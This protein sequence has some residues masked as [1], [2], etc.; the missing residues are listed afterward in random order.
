MAASSKAAWKWNADDNTEVYYKDL[1]KIAL[2]NQPQLATNFDVEK[3]Q[4]LMGRGVHV[5]DELWKMV[6]GYYKHFNR[7]V[8]IENPTNRVWNNR[9]KSAFECI[10]ERVKEPTFHKFT[11]DG[12]RCQRSLKCVSPLIQRYGHLYTCTDGFMFT[13]IQG[14]NII[15]AWREFVPEDGKCFLSIFYALSFY[16]LPNQEKLYITRIKA[17]ISKLTGDVSLYRF[18]KEFVSATYD[19]PY[20]WL[21]PIPP[22]WINHREDI[23]HVADQRGAP[24]DCH[25]LEVDCLKDLFYGVVL[26]QHTEINHW[27]LGSFMESEGTSELLTD[28]PTSHD[29]IDKITENI[30]SKISYLLEQK[31]SSAFEVQVMMHKRVSLMDMYEIKGEQVRICDELRESVSHWIR[32]VY[33]KQEELEKEGFG[34][35]RN[36]LSRGNQITW[37]S[38]PHYL[39]RSEE[40]LMMSSD[41][42][43]LPYTSYANQ[44]A[45]KLATSV[46][47]ATQ[48]LK[49]VNN[50]Y[51]PGGSSGQTSI[52]MI[53]DHV[54]KEGFCYMSIFVALGQQV[55]KNDCKAYTSLVDQIRSHLGAW[56]TFERI[57]K[58][59]Y[60]ILVKFP[61]LDTATI[62]TMV[63]NK[64]HQV[65]H[66]CDQRGQPNHTT[67]ILVDSLGD[68]ID[69]LAY[70]HQSWFQFRVG[71][72]LSDEI[73]HIGMRDEIEEIQRAI[74]GESSQE[75]PWAKIFKEEIERDDKVKKAQMWRLLKSHYEQDLM[76]SFPVRKT[77]VD[78]DPQIGPFDMMKF[79]QDNINKIRKNWKKWFRDGTM[80]HDIA[81]DPELSTFI[82]LSPATMTK[83]VRAIQGSQ[84]KFDS[85]AAIFE[86]DAN[87]IHISHLLKCMINGFGNTLSEKV[88]S[89]LHLKARELI[90]NSTLETR[91]MDLMKKIAKEHASFCSSNF[92]IVSS[93]ERS[94][95]EKNIKQFLDI[96][97][98]SEWCSFVC[99]LAWPDITGG[100]G[101][102]KWNGSQGEVG[103]NLKKLADNIFNRRVFMD[104]PYR[105]LHNFM[106]IFSIILNVASYIWGCCS[107]LQ[108]TLFF[109]RIAL[110]RFARMP[111]QTTTLL[112]FMTVLGAILY[113]NRNLFANFRKNKEFQS[114]KDEPPKMLMSFMAFAI[115]I[116]YIFS[117]DTA[118]MLSAAFNHF[119]RLASALI[120]TNLITGGKEFQADFLDVELEIT[121][122]EEEEGIVKRIKDTYGTWRL[123]KHMEGIDN[124]RPLEYGAEYG[125]QYVI[126]GG[127]AADVAIQ[128]MNTTKDWNFVLGATGSGKSTI[129]PVA[130][131]NLLRQQTKRK[132]R[133]L[134]LQPTR[135]ATRNVAGGIEAHFGQAIYVKHQDFLQQGHMG[136]Q[137]M[138][139]G[140]ALYTHM[141]NE[142]FLDQFDTIFLD[143]SHLISEHSLVF[144]SVVNLKTNI[145]KFYVTATPRVAKV[146][147]EPARRFTINKLQFDGKDPQAWL[148]NVMTGCMEDPFNYGK[149][150]LTF[151]TGKKEA[152][153]LASS[154]SSKIPEIK[155]HAVHSDNFKDVIGAVEADLSARE[156]K[157]MVFSTN[158]FETGVT[159]DVDVVVDFGF[160]MRPVLDLSEKTLLLEKKRVTANQREQRVG[161]CG[162]IKN[163]TALCF[164]KVMNNEQAVDACTVY[165]AAILSYVLDVD[166]YINSHL[167]TYWLENITR[168]QAT[169][170]AALQLPLFLTRD[171]IDSEGRV[172]KQIAKFLS[173]FANESLSM[174]THENCVMSEKYSSWPRLEEILIRAFRGE[175]PEEMQTISKER[176]PFACQNLEMG[177]YV[178]LVKALRDVKP[179]AQRLLRSKG[180]ITRKITLDLREPALQQTLSYIQELV[181]T[182]TKALCGYSELERKLNYGLFAN[183][184]NCLQAKKNVKN[185][186]SKIQRN[187]DKVTRLRSRVEE[188]INMQEGEHECDYY[189][190]FEIKKCLEFQ[191]NQTLTKEKVI[192]FCELETVETASITKAIV[193][194]DLKT[195]LWGLFCLIFALTAYLIYQCVQHIPTISTLFKSGVT[196]ES[197][198][199]IAKEYEVAKKKRQSARDK[200]NPAMMYS[201]NCDDVLNTYFGDD[202]EEKLKVRGKKKYDNAYITHLTREKLPWYVFYDISN[203]D[204]VEYAI[205][206]N[207]V[208]KEL[209]RTTKPIADIEKATEATEEDITTPLAH[210]LWADD[211]HDYY[212]EVHMKNGRTYKVHMTPHNPSKFVG[213]G[214][215]AGFPERNNVLRQT[216]PTKVLE[217]MSEVPHSK[218]NP[219]TPNMIGLLYEE[220]AINHCLH[221]IIYNHWL[222]IPGH[223]MTTPQNSYKLKYQGNSFDVD[224]QRVVHISGMDMVLVPKPT[225]LKLVKLVARA[226]EMI[227]PEEITFFYFSKQMKKFVQSGSRRALKDNKPGKWS[228]T[229]S[230]AKGMCGA[231]VISMNTGH[232]VGIHVVGDN[233]AKLNT[234]QTFNDAILN[235]L[236]TADK[237]FL[238]PRILAKP[239][240]LGFDNADFA[241]FQMR[242]VAF[243]Q[244]PTE[245]IDEK[246][247]E[248]NLESGE[249]DEIISVRV[250]SKNG[251]SFEMWNIKN[252]LVIRKELQRIERI[253]EGFSRDTTMY[254]MAN[255]NRWA[256]SCMHIQHRRVREGEGTSK[257]MQVK[258]VGNMEPKSLEKHR[259]LCES[260]HWLEFKELH[261]ELVANM[262]ELEWQYLPSKLN[263]AAYWKDLSKY[264]HPEIA[265]PDHK[266]LK[267]AAQWVVDHLKKNGM[268][269]TRVMKTEQV[270]EDLQWQ[271]AAGAVYMGAKGLVLEGYTQDQIHQI[272]NWSREG[273]LEGI[274]AGI[275]NASLKAELRP[276][277]KI[278]A[279]KTRVFTAAPLTTLLAS[280]FYVDSFNKQFYES[281]LKANHTVGINK[282]RRGWEKL[283]NKLNKPNSYWGGGDG[284][285]YDSSIEPF[286]FDLMVW[287]RMQFVAQEDKEEFKT[288]FWNMYREFVYTPIYC[289]DGTIVVKNLGQPS[290]QPSTVVDNTIILMISFTYA[291]IRK[292]GYNKA[293]DVLD[294]EQFNFV[295]NGDD[296]K[297]T[298]HESLVEENKFD[299]S[300]QFKELGLDYKF[301]ELTR[302]PFEHFYMSLQFYNTTEGIG[303]ALEAERLVAILQWKRGKRYMDVLQSIQAACVESYNR[304]EIFEIAS[305]YLRWFLLQYQRELA[306]EEMEEG[307]KLRILTEIETHNLHYQPESEQDTLKDKDFANKEFQMDV[308]EER[309]LMQSGDDTAIAEPAMGPVSRTPPG[310]NTIGPAAT[311]EAASWNL[312]TLS[313]EQIELAM[314][315]SLSGTPV[316]DESTLKA[317][318]YH[319]MHFDNTTATEDQVKDW[320]TYCKQ[321]Y[322]GS[323]QALSDSHFNKLKVAFIYWCADNGTSENHDFDA[324]TK[325]PTGPNASMELPLRPF[326]E[327]AK[328]VGLRKIMRFYSDLTVLLLKKRGTLTRWAI[329][330]GIRQ[331]EMV[332]FAFDFLKFDHKVTSV[333]R[334]ILTQA[335][336]GALGSGV[337]R[338]MLTD[339]NVSQGTSYERHTT[340]DVSEYEHGPSGPGHA[341]IM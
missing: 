191:S 258:V 235:I 85:I 30:L 66:F 124:T 324:R 129:F 317:I 242:K 204:M 294:K 335:K 290:G 229:I 39:Q 123:T 9:D 254:T 71:G 84:S 315:P 75:K 144:E 184:L 99:H 300:V 87:A 58:A 130:Y 177:I 60:A 19:M 187:L 221:A 139:Y 28:R 215:V 252:G 55:I 249:A 278:E 175:I 214:N 119:S 113:M 233:I 232:L 77:F 310:A 321:R 288:A 154:L 86:N 79:Y 90:D 186:I 68:I 61:Y 100:Y 169:L 14:A 32:D 10:I 265:K 320:E 199:N 168:E 309:R 226:R 34:T 203:D 106:L 121:E 53:K 304:K 176:I 165:S 196:S 202:V 213:H 97:S 241:N 48:Y 338:A 45:G 173:K 245:L 161:R 224:I 47:T 181:G 188:M 182:Y 190:N 12:K 250:E 24:E 17:L 13:G 223:I 46:T 336:A 219:E 209:F 136:I 325:V 220:G 231:P 227:T 281:H 216:G 192:E 299:L 59:L 155:T 6:E 3:L 337:K 279:N 167:S 135:A 289:I 166:I 148:R 127:N 198:R 332:P 105:V 4:N 64:D 248:K 253:E 210:A 103:S 146:K 163:G 20:L 153:T 126:Q 269:I 330:R 76:E 88:V 285:R 151:V 170:M 102:G 57:V 81:H 340:R 331:K 23:L 319:K 162:R 172:H 67:V 49:R 54:P 118:N 276:K 114:K 52:P 205:L 237:T 101:R 8:M 133:I 125:N 194:G 296:N 42:F 228:H 164:G 120:D 282:F 104:Y 115:L 43:K 128:A 280:K 171:L 197:I 157:V 38:I 260:D 35:L 179:T 156:R 63:I 72:T 193:E 218:A 274:N 62:P 312:G 291:L 78:A 37:K 298:V 222:I 56:P 183:K 138:T 316:L 275:W 131:Y 341:M 73:N 122:K 18:V 180:E 255:F 143:E 109:G 5:R 329:K 236:E 283:F 293:L 160:T 150:V 277:E 116:T 195:A 108:L 314:V 308:G 318:P 137:V 238:Q 189:D 273:L 211:C 311:G 306:Y 234:F 142:N 147:I 80:I 69:L 152:E 303:F 244:R 98:T 111:S 44:P 327:G 89:L 91:Q 36:V 201:E 96:G 200:R 145:V 207:D 262:H 132:H 178:L 74:K 246:S 94:L 302:D 158:I 208:G 264:D 65:I 174:N 41:V 159:M 243:L 7:A 239:S 326:L 134:I 266:A 107:M 185:Q 92:F 2:S 292:L 247:F 230:T 284:S 301:E 313:T 305:T 251:A 240:D 149:T 50:A 16:V 117:V 25:Q 334:E 33:V 95:H 22:I 297:F 40:I 212:Y 217:C 270:L 272:A 322:G 256:S 1:G 29:V 140:S 110:Q 141:S 328:S 257:Y 333:V 263:K 206:K 339:G 259:R 26:S 31:L 286:F 93:L 225:S 112:F 271:T 82:L 295:C 83:M 21:V 267:Q 261:P 11:H 27:K 51:A 323:G 268:G 15:P 70:T 307:G 287:V